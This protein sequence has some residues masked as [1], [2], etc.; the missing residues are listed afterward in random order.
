M[1]MVTTETISGYEIEEYLGYISE[2]VTLGIL[3]LVEMFQIADTF[4]GESSIYKNKFDEAKNILNKRLE[5]KAKEM[6]GNAIIGLRISY[7]EITGKGKSSLLISGT[8]TVVKAEMTEE[9]KNKLKEK[10]EIIEKTET[11][12]IMQM[13]ICNLIKYIEKTPKE[14]KNKVVEK[15]L[16]REDVK[17]IREVYKYFSLDGLYQEKIMN[18]NSYKLKD[19][20]VEK[21][22]IDS[23]IRLEILLRQIQQE[24]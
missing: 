12:N 23:N 22:R 20:P 10:I 18:M 11:E 3:G 2:T 19:N 13:Q 15:I 5:E 4:G 9:H 24:A 6:G 17:K 8:G 14:N 21:E 16:I 7:D 1:L